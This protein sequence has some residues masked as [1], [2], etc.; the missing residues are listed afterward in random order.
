[1]TEQL[2]LNLATANR[3]ETTSN[4]YYTPKWVFDA[5]N[6]TF[7]L[8]VSAPPNGAPFV[9][10]RH[11]YSILDDGLSQPWFGLVWMNPPF[12][13]P[14]PWVTKFLEHGNGVA[15][16]PTSNGKWFDLVWNNEQCNFTNLK[17]LK[18][19]TPTGPARG[20]LPNRCWL[21]G[22]G[23][24]TDVVTKSQLGKVR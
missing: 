4:D 13:N 19:H 12:S 1:M 14:L 9:P 3:Y 17:A 20:T 2:Q 15:L 23:T 6:T 7:D 16:L 10:C 18:F 8:D 5:L 21:V 11:H 22:M 24:G